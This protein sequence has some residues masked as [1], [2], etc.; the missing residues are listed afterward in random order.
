MCW[1]AGSCSYGKDYEVEAEED[2]AILVECLF[3]E[4]QEPSVRSPVSF[5]TA[6]I[7]LID[8]EMLGSLQD[9][10][11]RHHAS[12][13]QSS[14]KPLAEQI[15]THLANI[16]HQPAP[17]LVACNQTSESALW[18]LGYGRQRALFR[19]AIAWC[20][21]VYG[22]EFW[23]GHRGSAYERCRETLPHGS[24]DDMLGITVL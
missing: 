17:V 21:R 15:G 10:G 24:C 7:H 2:E 6:A 20:S 13:T 11:T 5:E 18:E 1:Y 4:R 14:L 12:A 19:A 9:R 23:P 22:D 16:V 3:Q 8:L